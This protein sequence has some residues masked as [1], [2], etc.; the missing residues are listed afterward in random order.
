MAE[1]RFCPRCATPLATRED[2]G[3][4]RLA[5]PKEGCGYVFYDNP[6]PVV[7]ALVEREG[8]IILARNKG[9]PEE[10]FGLVAGFLERGESPPEGVL[11]E[12]KEEL[13]LDGEIV[14]LIGLYPFPEMNQVII[15]Y[16]V[17]ARGEI[18]L[19][20]APAL[21]DGHGARGA[22]LARRE[23]DLIG[24]QVFFLSCT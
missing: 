1:M 3:R 23:K 19:G 21:A 13:G 11:R 8:A 12:V 24:A 15:A 4:D 2:G 18:A 10:W 17:R 14:S 7:S 5:C 9:W 20:E 22:R 6:T 16:H